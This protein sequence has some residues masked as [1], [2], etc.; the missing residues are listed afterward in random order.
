MSSFVSLKGSIQGM[1]RPQYG[2]HSE[3]ASWVQSPW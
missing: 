1:K 3:A 2:L